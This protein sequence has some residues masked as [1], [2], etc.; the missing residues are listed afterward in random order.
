MMKRLLSLVML[1]LVCGHFST[2]KAAD[3]SENFDGGFQQTWTFGN[4]LSDFSGPSGSFTAGIENDTLL[5][6]D[7]NSIIG[8]GAALGFGFVNESFS[9]VT[10]SAIINPT[11]QSDLNTFVGLAARADFSNLTGYVLTY[12]QSTG[13][14]DL[15][16]AN[17]ATQTGLDDGNIGIISTSIYAELTAVGSSITG[18]F[19][20]AP[21]GT[22][23]D[24]LVG[25]DT[26]YLNGVTG[27]VVQV[28][29]GGAGSPLVGRW[30]SL[31]AAAVPEPSTVI[32]LGLIGTVVA[33]RRRLMRNC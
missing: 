3:W 17:G 13:E 32:V 12:N 30:D 21:G 23:L 11:D 10:I 18:R 16:N 15:I 25:V 27:V 6:T 19:F 4:L 24:E 20:D 29:A 9:N 1:G 14:V 33:G 26:D 7:P 22:L 28:N 8:G 31:N 5:L 2:A